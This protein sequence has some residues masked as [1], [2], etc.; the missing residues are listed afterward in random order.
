MD[1]E[2]YPY[3][4]RLKLLKIRL[5]RIDKLI[6]EIDN[7]MFTMGYLLSDEA[8]KL[9][10]DK[11]DELEKELLEINAQIIKIEGELDYLGVKEK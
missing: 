4:E 8:Y 5:S 9:S 10:F 6:N 7:Q 1:Y 2:K 11:R 3:P